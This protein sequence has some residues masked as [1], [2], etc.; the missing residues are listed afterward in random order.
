MA[1]WMKPGL[2]VLKDALKGLEENVF[3][4]AI[5]GDKNALAVIAKE[6][7][8]V[9]PVRDADQQ[10]LVNNVINPE[11]SRRQ[12]FRRMGGAA[13][14]AALEMPSPL[15]FLQSTLEQVKP[16]LQLNLT[17]LEMLKYSQK[18]MDRDIDLKHFPG[19]DEGFM[20]VFD[21]DE[22]SEIGQFKNVRH[23]LGQGVFLDPKDL[24]PTIRAMELEPTTNNLESLRRVIDSSS[25]F[26]PDAIDA[27]W[28]DVKH[29]AQ[30]FASGDHLSADRD[31][32]LSAEDFGLSP[33]QFEK[34]LEAYLS[35]LHQSNDSSRVALTPEDGFIEGRRILDR[36]IEDEAYN[37]G[38]MDEVSSNDSLASY[39]DDELGPGPK[40]EDFLEWWDQITPESEVRHVLGDEHPLYS[41]TSDDLG[42]DVT[43]EQ[44]NQLRK[45]FE[46]RLKAYN[47]GEL[48][49]GKPVP[50]SKP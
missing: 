28:D 23:Q 50:K 33:D 22:P 27:D 39:F 36:H 16:S 8:Q 26:H 48:E 38:Y 29:Q 11:M 20:R 47:N 3:K 44:V 41:I 40:A 15:R 32:E 34:E 21:L 19:G 45:D 43:E 4:R 17:P 30:D 14:H 25:R 35:K 49:Y 10:A 9:A 42:H 18:Y 2:M 7:G 1:N 5:E 6:Q 46:D 31:I 37:R 24:I 12:L 13:A